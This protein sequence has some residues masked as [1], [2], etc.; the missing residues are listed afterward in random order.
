MVEIGGGMSESARTTDDGLGLDGAGDE[1]VPEPQ[2][3]LAARL[4][5]ARL[6]SRMTQQQAAQALGMS[7][8]LLV[9]IEKG[10]RAVRPDELVALAQLYQRPVGE[11]VRSAAPPEGL[12]AQF[13]LA[14]GSDR[15]AEE[16]HDLVE[17]LARLGDDY[18][19][20]A[21][22]SETV[23]PRRYPA[24]VDI[25]GLDPQLAAEDVAAGERNRLGLGDGPLIQLR[26]VLEDEVGVRVFVP[27]LPSQVA[28]LFLYAEQLGGCVAVNARHPRERQRWSLSHEFGHFL[29]TRSRAEVTLVHQER[30][31]AHERFA[32][33]FAANFL[34]PRDGLRRRY[35]ELAQTRRG[36]VTAADVLRLAH[37][38]QVSLQAMAL[39]LEDLRLLP[40]GSFDRLVE[41]GFRPSEAHRL[42]GLER[43]A[44][45]QD[46]L[47]L[48]YR[49]LAAEL[50]LEGAISE[51]QLARFL[52]VDR[53]RA[54]AMVAALTGSSDVTPEGSSAHVRLTDSSDA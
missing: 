27:E 48:R 4:R 37:T 3:A 39:R 32:D 7:R 42:L 10:A 16:L 17:E 44:P 33:A 35:H 54:R 28:G 52:R 1:Q 18:L 30:T 41:S 49:Y 25:H 45:D 26:E 6:G 50:L 5:N 23:L 19:E 53:V 31:S 12:G 14:F 9:A 21:R 13:R 36:Q 24:M 46:L 2:D 47:P 43:A 40:A 20:L 38:Y 34:I 8:P 11:L 15:A 22:L 51:G 29:T